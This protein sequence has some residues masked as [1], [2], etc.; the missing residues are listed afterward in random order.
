[1][2]A[3][4]LVS[5]EDEEIASQVGR[6]IDAVHLCGIAIAS[7]VV[8]RPVSGCANHITDAALH[9]GERRRDLF[10]FIH[11][12]GRL[13]LRHHRLQRSNVGA[14]EL[15]WVCVRQP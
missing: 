3:Q 13:F 8:A 5:F 12:G 6:Y 14:R 4:E 15:N 10:S 1:M 9:P 7:K 2:I 11:R